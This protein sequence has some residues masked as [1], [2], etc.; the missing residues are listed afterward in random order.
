MKNGQYP[1]THVTVNYAGVSIN[2]KVQQHIIHVKNGT[3]ER[4][5]TRF[6]YNGLYLVIPEDQIENI[7]KHYFS[8]N[9]GREIFEG[10]SKQST[11]AS[12]LD[13]KGRDFSEKQRNLLNSFI[14]ET[15]IEA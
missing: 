3:K 12:L 1:N 9:S 6:E 8:E 7:S 5:F 10:K 11:L 14:P 2:G 13:F 15:P 4:I